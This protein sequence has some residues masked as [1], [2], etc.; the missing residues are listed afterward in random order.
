MSINRTQFYDKEY[1]VIFPELYLKTINGESLFA[2][3]P[4]GENIDIDVENGTQYGYASIT[5]GLSD[6]NID[7]YSYKVNEKPFWTSYVYD[8]TEE[9]KSTYPYLW[10][11]TKTDKNSYS[12]V[13]FGGER[14]EVKKNFIEGDLIQIEIDRNKKI[15]EDKTYISKIQFLNENDEIIELNSENII[16][17]KTNIKTELFES[18]EDVS[19]DFINATIK[20]DEIEIKINLKKDY[21][22]KDTNYNF[23]KN[24]SIEINGKN[25]Y[26]TPRLFFVN[27]YDIEIESG[28]GI[29]PQFRINENGNWE[30]SYDNGETWQEV[31]RATGVDGSVGIDSFSITAGEVS[32]YCDKE[33]ITLQSGTSKIVADASGIT[34]TGCTIIN[35]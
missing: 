22:I 20:D 15:T 18:I 1:N 30:V 29:T 26:L 3:T 25:Y 27:N 21:I 11:R 24:I 10:M 6:D 13:I 23:N 31:D 4:N 34:L 33:S 12:Y 32:L 8:L 14:K 5:F 17:E 16:L 7:E 2:A 28:I 35:D 19:D 9:E